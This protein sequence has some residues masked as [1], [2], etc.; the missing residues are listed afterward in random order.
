MAKAKKVQAVNTDSTQRMTVGI[1]KT[2]LMQVGEFYGDTG[3]MNPRSIDPLVYMLAERGEATFGG[4]FIDNCKDGIAL[5]NAGYPKQKA[6][7]FLADRMLRKYVAEAF[8]TVG[9]GDVGSDLKKMPPLSEATY[10]DYFMKVSRLERD[11]FRTN[12]HPVMNDL[13]KMV[14]GY[15]TEQPNHVCDTIASFFKL[16]RNQSG[17]EEL[18]GDLCKLVKQRR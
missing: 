13:A 9:K 3:L 16:T 2:K 15:Q 11:A 6:L 17:M 18:L 1:R 10:V 5:S 14:S 12:I 8:V 4:S 7:C